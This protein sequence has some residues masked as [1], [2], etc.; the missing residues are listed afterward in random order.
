MHRRPLKAPQAVKVRPPLADLRARLKA[1]PAAGSHHDCP[2]DKDKQTLLLEFWPIRRHK[3][4]ARELGISHTTAL[5]WY[6]RLSD[7]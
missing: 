5:M 4:V 7:Q 1:L 3:L 6:R 2:L